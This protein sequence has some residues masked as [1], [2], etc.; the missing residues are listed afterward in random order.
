M[1]HTQHTH[2]QSSDRIRNLI[3][4]ESNQRNSVIAR[5][6]DEQI[7]ASVRHFAAIL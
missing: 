4:I 5:C 7:L 1:N 3:E 6:D 2:N